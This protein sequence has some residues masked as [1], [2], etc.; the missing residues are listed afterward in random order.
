MKREIKKGADLKYYE[1]SEREGIAVIWK[2]WKLLSEEM[3][4]GRGRTV[5]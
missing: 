4:S 3:D 1:Q 5:Q 2:I